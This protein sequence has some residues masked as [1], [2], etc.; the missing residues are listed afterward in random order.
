MSKQIIS[1]RTNLFEPNV[2]IS[3]YVEIAGSPSLKLLKE[4]IQKAFQCNELT[5]SKVIIDEEGRAYYQKL[6]QTGCKVIIAESEW[7]NII[8]ENEK[9][10]F[11][12]KQGELMR[13][14]IK[15]NGGILFMAHHLVGDG[16]SI[17]VFLQDVLTALA[18]NEIHY[19]PADI[20]TRESL[21]RKTKLNFFER[22]YLS[23]L[24]KIWKKE[25]QCY[26]WD[27]YDAIHQKYWDGHSSNILTHT[28]SVKETEHIKEMARAAKVTVNSYLISLI[29]SVRKG[30]SVVGIPVDI[31]ENDDSMSNQ[32]SGIAINYRYLKHKKIQ[33]NARAIHK[34]I[35]KM[36]SYPKKRYFVLLFLAELCPT[37]I[38]AVLLVTHGLIQN[39]TVEK[40]AYVFGYKGSKKRDL[41]VTN[42]GVIKNHTDYDK[43]KINNIIFVPPSVSYSQHII[44]I[45]TI[46][47]RITI[48]YHGMGEEENSWFE[49]L[50]CILS[51]RT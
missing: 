41:G 23:H 1:E 47:E 38:D 11:A 5:M 29:L 42:L 27:S 37:L 18:G 13:V 20:L 28:F 14:F 19:K 15:E 21:R 32:V 51:K 40:A 46:N 26:F 22:R 17:I 50:V 43:Y 10:P 44:G 48:T 39:K 35:N 30:L 7:K 4:A 45:S 36:L 33:E 2:Y 12:I 31:R 3:M 8:K 49:E 25:E 16:K 9:Q 24:N 34:K 6:K